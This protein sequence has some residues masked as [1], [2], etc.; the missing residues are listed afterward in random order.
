MKK[1]VCVLSACFLLCAGIFAEGESYFE[2]AK[3]ERPIRLE[4]AVGLTY[5][6]VSVEA[7]GAYMF[8]IND[9]LRWDAGLAYHYASDSAL[10]WKANT[11][12]NRVYN[13]GDYKRLDNF[14]SNDILAFASF[15]FG[16]WYTTYGFG[17]GINTVGGAS[18]IPVDLRIGWQPG[19]RNNQRVS[20]KGEFSLMGSTWGQRYISNTTGAVINKFN[21]RVIPLLNLG[22]AV[23][24]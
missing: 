5:G 16:D 20:F 21:F 14:N 6:G 22:I 3:V 23:R 10:E 12:D 9:T 24:I 19:A 4:A 8:K 13:S 1:I 18:V 15:W 2:T 17:F 11:A 7:R